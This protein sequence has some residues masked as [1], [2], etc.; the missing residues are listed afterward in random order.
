MIWEDEEYVVS[1]RR[2]FGSACQRAGV[3]DC[4]PECIA[5]REREL[6]IACRSVSLSGSG[7]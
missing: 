4:V 5:V 7:G 2:N 3:K 1:L 6:G